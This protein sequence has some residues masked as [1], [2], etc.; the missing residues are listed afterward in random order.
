LFENPKIEQRIGDSFDIVQTF[1]PNSF[2]RIL[3]DP[4]TLALAGDL[5]SEEFYRELF[6]VLKP[7]G[8]LFHYVGDPAGKFGAGVTRGVMERLSGARFKRVTKRADAF[9]VVAFK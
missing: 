8:K 3:H 2:D 9:G 6:R 1:A 5:Y 7:G 4:P